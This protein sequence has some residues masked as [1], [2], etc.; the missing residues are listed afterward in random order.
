LVFSNILLYMNKNKF[1]LIIN[2]FCLSLIIFSVIYANNLPPNIPSCTNTQF[3]GDTTTAIEFTAQTTDSNNEK[4]AYQFNWGD[5]LISPWLQFTNSGYQFSSEHIYKITGMFFCT[6]RAK[7]ESDNISDWSLPCT[8]SILPSLLKWKYESGSGIYSGV[9]LGF[10]NEIYLTCEDGTLH[11]LN[12]DGTLRWKFSTLGSI[13]SAPVIGEDAIYITST[14]GRIYAIDFNGKE[15][16]KLKMDASSYSTPAVGKNSVIYFGCDDSN[17][18]AISKNGKL[19]WKYKTGDEIAGSPII[20][21]DGTIYVA[22]DA[23]YALNTKGK[24]KWI[25]RPISEEEAYFFASP[26]IDHDGTI[27]IGATDGALYGITQQGRLEFRALT[28]DEDEIRA[29]IAIDP[30]GVAYFGAQNYVLNKKEMYGEVAPV[31]ETDYYIYS[32]PA[33]DSLGNI[34]FVSDDGYLYC[35][36]YDGRLLF[37]WEIADDSKEIM[38]SPSPLIADDGTVYV[39]SWTGQLYAFCG[40]AP[41]AKNTWSLFR[42]DL[43]NTGCLDR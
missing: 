13:Y 21:Q 20:D 36:R 1:S 29:G 11:S 2:I 24:E 15:L 38:Y 5:G 34:Y 43:Q 35:I 3:Y 32:A 17:L 31:F 33:I 19:L 41:A 16:W 40:F 9:G 18:Y 22:S 7:D 42:H 12:P 39:G 6:V 30:K 25:F 27:Y 26:S 23:F 10:H 28:P 37:K 14:E 8:L 4:I